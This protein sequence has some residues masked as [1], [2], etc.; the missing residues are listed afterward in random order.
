MKKSLSIAAITFLQGLRNQTFRVVGLMFVAL[1][2][3][4]YILR[5]LSIGHKDLMLR[6]F[7]LSAMEISGLLL[8]IFGCVSGFYRERETRLRSI[9][10]T[11]VSVFDHTLGKL[12][13]NILLI[14]VFLFLLSL[15]GS[16]VLWHESAWHPSVIYGVYSIFLKLSIICGFCSLFASLFTSSVFASLTTVL[17]YVSAEFS[18]Y[19]LMLLQKSGAG[20]SY[21]ISRIVYHLLPNFDKIDLKYAATHADQVNASQLFQLSAYTLFYLALIFIFSWKASSRNER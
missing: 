16:G 6:S 17:V 13:G 21:S 7:G 1:L 8:I 3:L 14:A 12:V 2:G 19:P 9:Y 20:M 15:A 4:A 5:V 18:H 11:Y 10:L